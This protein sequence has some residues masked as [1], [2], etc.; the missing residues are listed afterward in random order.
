MTRCL[1]LLA[2]LLPALAAASPYVPASD[3]VV[4]EQLP[5]QRPVALAASATGPAAPVAGREA[6]IRDL[7]QQ[8]RRGGDPRYL[9]Y[10]EAQL[11]GL[12]AGS[13][14]DLLQARL[15]QAQH[16][17]GE[18]R[19]L[20]AAVLRRQPDDPEALLLLASI[21]L[22][23]GDYDRAHDSCSRLGGLS[24]LPLALACRAQVDGLRGRGPAALRQLQQLSALADSLAPDQRTW[25]QLALGDLA[26]RLGDEELAGAAYRRVQ[27]DSVDARAAYADWLLATGRQAAVITLLRDST[28]SDGLL[29]RLALAEQQLGLPAAALHARELRQRVDALAA[30]GDDTHLREAAVLALHLERDIPRALDLARRNWEQQRE[31]ADLL[32]YARAA[33][34]AGA[35]RD[36]ALLRDW[37]RARHLQDRRLDREIA[38][39]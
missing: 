16:R 34:A 1:P 25:L 19:A 30:R 31:P 35:T 29:L 10:A 22:V 24:L 9:G 26:W 15:R 12:P 7:L 13:S 28:R 2:W 14:R 5:A 38:A 6:A 36:L 3:A 11:N 37:R 17:F 23:R 27:A 33:R 21:D 39:R 20:L 18:A 32:L 4:L 8:A